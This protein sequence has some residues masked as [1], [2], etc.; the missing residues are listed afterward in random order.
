MM[1]K[2][3]CSSH[4]QALMICWILG[5]LECCSPV[6]LVL[7]ALVVVGVAGLLAV[8]SSFKNK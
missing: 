5:F 3:L 7:N 2:G 6:A 4:H 1:M 8:G